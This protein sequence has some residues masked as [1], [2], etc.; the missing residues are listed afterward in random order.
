MALTDRFNSVI[1]K[2]SRLVVLSALFIAVI[3]GVFA[4]RFELDASSESLVLENDKS[5][6]YYRETRK[7][8]GRYLLVVVKYLNGEGFIVTSFYTDKIRGA[9]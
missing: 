1:E 8:Y 5:L 7:R 9:K 4:T 2:H 6:K 3:A